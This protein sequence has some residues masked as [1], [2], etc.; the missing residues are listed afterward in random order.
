MDEIP[1]AEAAR[2]L[3]L[4]EWAVRKMITA[5]RLLNRARSGP[6]LVAAADV[7]RI[8]SDRR[9]EA[10]RRHRDLT[11]FARAVD[12]LLH[13]LMTSTPLGATGSGFYLLPT[14]RDALKVLPPDAFAVFGRDVLEAAAVRD[15][16]R[17]DGACPT[18]FA[19]MASRVHQ[20][21]PP[22]NG[23]AY[24]A[25]LGEPCP[26][27]VRRFAEQTAE[28]RRTADRQR[29]ADT[30]RRAEAERDHARAEFSAAHAAAETAAQRVRS[31]A[32]HLATLDPQIAREA[33]AQ[34][35]RRG[36][37]KAASR[38]PDWCTCDADRQC[39]RHAAADRRAARR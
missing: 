8:R 28:R 18:C 23:Q 2:R 6:A 21:H 38:F 35:R 31:A 11:A 14:G 29:Q 20:T 7:D 39:P 3:G 9:T 22:E 32:R 13:P 4:T 24:R 17:R 30:A 5:G 15:Q 1:V 19:H 27:D 34:A 36:A 25:L 33:T 26:V 37:F 12:G 16:L 10:L